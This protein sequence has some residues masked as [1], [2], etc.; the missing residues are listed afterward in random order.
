MDARDALTNNADLWAEHFRQESRARLD[1]WGLTETDWIESLADAMSEL[2]AAQ[3]AGL[4]AFLVAPPIAELF[5]SNA[6]D[7]THFLQSDSRSDLS[8]IPA[9]FR[10]AEERTAPAA[11]EGPSLAKVAAPHVP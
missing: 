1:R 10:A 2:A 5:R 3:V 9:E 8:E 7:V 6:P 4:I 11:S